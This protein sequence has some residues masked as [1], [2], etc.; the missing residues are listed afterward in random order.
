MDDPPS[1]G[2]LYDTTTET[3][4][5]D[6]SSLSP[7]IARPSLWSILRSA[8][9]NMLLPFVNGMMLGF[10]EIMAHE[11]AFRLGWGGTRVFPLG[12]RRQVGPGVEM[13][14]YGGSQERRNERNLNRL[15]QL[16]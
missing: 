2:D 14:D 10:G 7:I 12:R 11:F 15:D 5:V 16:D 4:D 6:E 1:E 3:E 8:V 9:I 13:T